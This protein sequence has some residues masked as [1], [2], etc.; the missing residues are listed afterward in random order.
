MGILGLHTLVYFVEQH[1][2]VARAIVYGN[3]AYPFAAVGINVTQ[4][5]CNLLNLTDGKTKRGSD[6][7]WP[8]HPCARLW[9]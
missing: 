3:R 2:A 5:L 9:G 4:L 8:A 1:T 6:G 7:R